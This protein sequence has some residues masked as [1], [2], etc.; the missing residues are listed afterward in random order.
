VLRQAEVPDMHVKIM[1]SL[2]DPPSGIGEVGTPPVAPA[3]ANAI[4]AATGAKLRHLPMTPER[5]KAAL[6]A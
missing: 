6:K 1:P 3:I 2:K 5:V 4:A